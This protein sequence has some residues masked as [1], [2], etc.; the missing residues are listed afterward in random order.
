M[1]APNALP[2]RLATES[3]PVPRPLLVCQP[4][5]G[6]QHRDVARTKTLFKPGGYSG[7][8]SWASFASTRTLEPA[9]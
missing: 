3:F 6:Y 7:R 9:A 8:N 4:Y 1:T 5:P 2:E